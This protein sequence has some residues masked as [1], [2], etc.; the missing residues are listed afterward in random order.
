[1][2]S[3]RSRATSEDISL[4]TAHFSFSLYSPIWFSIDWHQIT[5]FY[6]IALTDG[7]NKINLAI[8]IREYL[9]V[10]FEL[11]IF[12]EEMLML[13]ESGSEPL[14]SWKS[15]IV[16]SWIANRVKVSSHAPFPGICSWPIQ[17]QGSSCSWMSIEFSVHRPSELCPHC[18][19]LQQRHRQIANRGKLWFC[20]SP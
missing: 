19:T 20:V 13:L 14:K 10:C 7:T 9:K 16:L 2:C 3:C 5:E 4:D 17:K 12:L 1:M 18:G 15:L 11:E 6:M 8:L